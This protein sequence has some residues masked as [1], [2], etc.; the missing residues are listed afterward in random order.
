ME[1]KEKILKAGR[2]LF[3]EKGY[4]DTNV[5]EITRKAT[6]ATGTFYNYFSSKDHLFME[7]FLE[8]NRKLKQRI[9][10]RIDPD[11]DPM[12]IVEELM[13]LNTVGMQ[14]NTILR[15]WYNREAF[16]RIE[17]AY[18]EAKG[19]E[20][21]GFMYDGFFDFVKQWQQKGIM[22]EDIPPEMVMAIFHAIITI[23]THKKE[24][25]IQYFP[26]LMDHLVRFVME[27]LKKE[28]EP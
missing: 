23:D 16:E 9:M 21:V 5:S 28:T 7:L 17:H 22:R 26:K 11:Q 18:R 20:Y 10:K 12:S 8:E 4:K 15:E 14:K 3:M 19:I 6:M 13:I 1:K 2:S 25:G 27:G 24:I